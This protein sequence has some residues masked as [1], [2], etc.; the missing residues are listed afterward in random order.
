MAKLSRRRL[1]REVVRLLDEPKAGEVVQQLAAYLITHKMANQIDL[2][3]LDIA[4]ELYMQRGHLDAHVSH[5]SELSQ[6]TKDAI[7]TLLKA[8]TG[9]KTVELETNLQANLLGG[10][11]VRTPR[12]ELDTSVKS[13]LKQI[14]LGGTL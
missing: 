11:V 6:A 4:D 8:T 13:Q 7:S 1:A 9:A 5:M 10:V 14:S 12:Y 3:M 2:L